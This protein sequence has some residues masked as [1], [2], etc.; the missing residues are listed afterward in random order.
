[1]CSLAS[2]LVTVLLSLNCSFTMRLKSRFLSHPNIFRQ[3]TPNCVKSTMDPIF[4]PIPNSVLRDYVNANCYVYFGWRD[5]CDGCTSAPIKAGRT[6]GLSGA[7]TSFG[8][9]STC[10][11]R[12]LFGQTLDLAGINTDGDVDGNDKFYIGIKCH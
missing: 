10:Q 7:C 6:R 11:N 8:G 9:D 12:S 2:G 3:S 1:M 5:S 4:M